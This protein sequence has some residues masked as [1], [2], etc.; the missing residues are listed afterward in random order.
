MSLQRSARDPRLSLDERLKIL[1]PM[2]NEEDT[3]LPR[4]WSVKDKFNYIGL[5]QVSK[6]FVIV[7]IFMMASQHFNYYSKSFDLLTFRKI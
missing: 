3:P 1:Y 4:C 7:I 6:P 5:S 2:V